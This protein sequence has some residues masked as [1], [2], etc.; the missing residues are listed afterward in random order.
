MKLEE[1]HLSAPSTANLVQKNSTDLKNSCSISETGKLE[2]A[3]YPR[4][5]M[6]NGRRSSDC[7]PGNKTDKGPWEVVSREGGVARRA[8]C[9]YK[10]DVDKLDFSILDEDTET[11][12]EG[13][14]EETDSPDVDDIE[15]DDI[16]GVARSIDMRVLEDFE[17]A[18]R[19]QDP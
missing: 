7:G 11:A 1:A 15:D 17:S 3:I 19:E 9:V 18:M 6:R 10:K 14:D 4:I 13:E 16:Y 8:K 2:R 12:S 5:L